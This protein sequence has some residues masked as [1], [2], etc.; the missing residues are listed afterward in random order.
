MRGAYGLAI[1]GDLSTHDALRELDHAHAT[2]RIV[3]V[4]AIPDLAES[5]DPR[6]TCVELADGTWFLLNDLGGG[7]YVAT[8]CGG[9]DKTDDEL[10]HPYLAPIA[11]LINRRLGHAALHA[12]ALSWEGS[13]LLLIGEPGH[14]KTTTATHLASLGADL[15]ADDLTVITPS[16]IAAGPRTADL[17]PEGASLLGLSGDPVRG[18]TR[19]RRAM[20]PSWVPRV[21]VAAFVHLAFGAPDM[22][23]TPASGRLLALSRQLYWPTVA[24]GAAT[25]LS[26]ASLPH[27]TLTR[28]RGRS[29]LDFAAGSLRTLARSLTSAGSPPP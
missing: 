17:R 27:V 15:L 2:L 29:G 18:G 13:G 8:L 19:S 6:S 22:S 24:G 14:G 20:S 12:A 5:L 28:P 16:G 21:P 3:V 25:L 11:A 23:E 1:L 10:V 9:P 26:L 4:P 7:E